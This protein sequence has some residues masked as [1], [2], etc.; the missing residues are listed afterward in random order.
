MRNGGLSYDISHVR[1]VSYP[2]WS[3]KIASWLVSF[4]AEHVC[5]YLFDCVK[6]Y[7][8]DY[9]EQY[10]KITCNNIIRKLIHIYIYD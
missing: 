2:L 8:Y 4:N 7:M 6:L 5:K 9:M 3:E 1:Y 10:S